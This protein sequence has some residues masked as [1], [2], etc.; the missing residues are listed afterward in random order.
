MEWPEDK[1][2][3]KDWG[4]LQIETARDYCVDSY[5]WTY[6]SGYLNYQ[7]IHHLFPGI[8]PHFYPELLPII[9]EMC[10]EYKI[11]YKCVESYQYVVDSHFKHLSQFQ[12]PKDLEKFYRVTKLNKLFPKKE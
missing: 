9:K 5:F 7:I 12:S 3:N 6:L 1:F 2:I 4:I 11:N 8:N 10:L